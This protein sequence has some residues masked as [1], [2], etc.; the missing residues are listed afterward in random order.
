MPLSSWKPLSVAWSSVAS[1]TPARQLVACGCALLTPSGSLGRSQLAFPDIL[2]VALTLL[3]PLAGLPSQ[4]AQ[5]HAYLARSFIC[6]PAHLFVR[7][8]N[9]YH[10]LH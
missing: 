1:C 7:L 9:T 8:L 2:S 3:G 10:W 6:S 5:A 4:R